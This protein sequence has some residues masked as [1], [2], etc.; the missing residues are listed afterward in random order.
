MIFWSVNTLIL[1]RAE[2]LDPLKEEYPM[3]VT[4][5]HLMVRAQ[6]WKSR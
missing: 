6:V 2:K 4:K 5:L 3:Y 1:Y